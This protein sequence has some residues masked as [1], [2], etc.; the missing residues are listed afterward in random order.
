MTMRDKLTIV[1]LIALL[2]GGTTVFFLRI[3]DP[4]RVDVDTQFKSGRHLVFAV[5]GP[6]AT[7]DEA[8]R[9]AVARARDHLRTMADSSGEYFS[10]IG[11]SDH[12][13]VQEGLEILTWLGPF[14]EVD[15]GRNW[16]NS[17]IREL[18]N[19]SGARPAVPQIVV[20][21]ETIE[22]VPL[23]IRYMDRVEHA[24]FV[25]RGEIQEWANRRFPLSRR[26]RGAPRTVGLQAPLS[27]RGVP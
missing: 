22:L 9:T 10:T 6:T 13:N 20:F 24:R 23:P 3:A 25:G 19:S 1:G 8:L 5:I 4:V 16:L 14:D 15:V 26:T 7:G 2:T 11:V 17:G 12:W 21:S 18:I 27:V